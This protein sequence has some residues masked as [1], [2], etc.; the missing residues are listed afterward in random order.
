[1]LPIEPAQV[2]AGDQRS[3]HVAGERDIPN[4]ER[5][6]AGR[7]LRTGAIGG[8]HQ[9]RIVNDAD[10]ADRCPFLYRERARD[11]GNDVL[12]FGIVKIDPAEC[13]R[14]LLSAKGNCKGQRRGN[15]DEAPGEVN[16][17]EFRYSRRTGTKG[18]REQ[19]NETPH[20]R[21]FESRYFCAVGAGLIFAAKS[22]GG[23]SSS[24]TLVNSASQPSS[25]P[26]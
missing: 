15:C 6:V 19:G 2:D 24:A 16:Q 13:A 8:H 9:R 12:I 1:M 23:V 17:H 18:S 10:L 11:P 25:A 26:W 5:V 4:C 21:H 3:H 22:G 20:A 7:R 14:R